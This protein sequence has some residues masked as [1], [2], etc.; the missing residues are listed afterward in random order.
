MVRCPNWLSINRVQVFVNGQPSDKENFSERTH[1]QMFRRET[2]VFD[3]VIPLSLP[4]DA[5]VIVA[6]S[7][8]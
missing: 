6:C 7:N 5:H 8:T 1:P 4:R 2:T 3:Q